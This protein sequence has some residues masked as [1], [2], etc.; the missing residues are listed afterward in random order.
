[1][2][3]TDP[4]LIRRKLAV[5]V[6]NLQALESVVSMPLEQYQRDLFLR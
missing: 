3:P 4:A 5:I 6:D 2:T 1:M